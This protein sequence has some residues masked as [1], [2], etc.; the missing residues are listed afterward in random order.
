MHPNR[1]KFEI[2]CFYCRKLG[3]IATECKKKKYHEEQQKKK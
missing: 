3:H 2:K 1:N